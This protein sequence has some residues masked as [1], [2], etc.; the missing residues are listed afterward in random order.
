[1]IIQENSAHLVKA[2][3]SH[4]DAGSDMSSHVVDS[5]NPG[6]PKINDRDHDAGSQTGA[7]DEYFLCSSG[8]SGTSRGLIE[9]QTL[10]VEPQDSR[11]RVDP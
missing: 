9:P 1:M 10:S 11:Q 8:S 4:V 5:I 3:R 2:F 6:S 7:P